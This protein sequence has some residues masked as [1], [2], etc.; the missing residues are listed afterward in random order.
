MLTPC[1]DK[2]IGNYH[3]EVCYYESIID[4]QILHLSDPGA[5]VGIP[6]DRMS[7]FIAFK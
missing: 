5:K 7:S 3:C 1:I 2:M 6:W 4:H